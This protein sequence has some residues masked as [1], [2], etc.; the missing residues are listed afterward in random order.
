MHEI[1]LCGCGEKEND[2][3]FFLMLNN[4][5][6]PIHRKINNRHKHRQNS[7]FNQTSSQTITPRRGDLNRYQVSHVLNHLFIVIAFEKMPCITYFIAV[8][9]RLC[10]HACT[11]KCYSNNCLQDYF[12]NNFSMTRPQIQVRDCI[13]LSNASQIMWWSI[14]VI[15]VG[16]EARTNKFLF[17]FFIYLKD[18]QQD[19][20]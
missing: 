10:A 1:P 12:A 16:S 7:L 9:K 19:Y 3:I 2:V 8:C 5:T 17:S 13:Q 11:Y 20:T 14:S 15:F 4:H 6:Q 18:I